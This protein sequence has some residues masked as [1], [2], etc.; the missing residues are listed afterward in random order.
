MTCMMSQHSSG[1]VGTVVVLNGPSSSGKSS[2]ARA[3]QDRWPGLLLDGGLDR[4]LGMLP[5]AYL[6]PSWSQVYRYAYGP[7]GTIRAI[8]VGPAGE[9]LH[10]GM[11]RAVAALAGSGCDVVVDHV[12]LE[13]RWALDLVQVLEGV[14][15]VLVGVRLP[16]EVL[17]RRERERADRTLGQALAQLPAVHSHGGYDVQVDTSVLT[18][19]EAAEV[20]LGRVGADRPPTAAARWR[21]Q[22]D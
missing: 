13:R 5:R 4:H 8:S 12:L 14:P 11:H 7:D 6:G 20:V 3:L 9:R 22:P 16:A 2:L 15:T 21:G 17:A 1:G 19:D 18:P 10:R